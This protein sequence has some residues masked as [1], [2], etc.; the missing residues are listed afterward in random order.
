MFQTKR[1][2]SKLGNV[3][4]K[5]PRED[6]SEHPNWEKDFTSKEEHQEGNFYLHGKHQN[7]MIE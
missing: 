3:G 1:C 7:K 4:R 6:L 2:P 5:I